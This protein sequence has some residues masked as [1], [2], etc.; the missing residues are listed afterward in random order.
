MNKR[1]F[2]ETPG[3]SDILPQYSST[4]LDKKKGA[5]LFSVVGGKLSEG[6]NFQDNLARAVVMV[7]LPYPNLYSSELL[8][9]KRHIEQKVISAGGSLK[10]AKSATNEFYE[11]ICMKA[12][13]QSI[14]RAIRH[15]NDYACIYLVDNRYLNNK[16]QHKL[17]EWV[18][19]R[20]KSELK[21]SEIFA[22]TSVFFASNR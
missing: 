10:D 11:N 2:Y 17:S 19:K 20:V 12:V 18:R 15:A 5:F 13:N 21:T 8:V 7:G 4:I 9:K 1:I 16:V 3:G 6:I 22:Q 14:G